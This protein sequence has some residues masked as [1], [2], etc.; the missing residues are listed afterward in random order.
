MGARGEVVIHV[1]G[2]DV[3]LFFSLEAL[4]S[5][6]KQLG[7]GIPDMLKVYYTHPPSY[8]DLVA[9]LRAGMEAARME[10]RTGTRPV[11][12]N[13]AIDVIKEIGYLTVSPLVMEALATVWSYKPDEEIAAEGDSDPN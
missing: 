11:S 12:N 9:L 1:K 5:A 2:R 7:K 13:D 4:L 8:T 10:A 3:Y 6:E